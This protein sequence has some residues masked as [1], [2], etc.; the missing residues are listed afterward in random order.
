MARPESETEYGPIATRILYEDDQVRIWDQRLA[1][2][3]QT[4][5]HRHDQDYVLVDVAGE[6]IGV[7]PLP[8]HNNKDYDAYIEIPVKRGQVFSVGAGSVEQAR[9]VGGVAYRGILVE[10]KDSPRP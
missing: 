6:R 7:T 4:A 9:N 2:G 3:E 1:P 5:P 10:F 8:G